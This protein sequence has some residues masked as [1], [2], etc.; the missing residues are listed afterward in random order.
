M[1]ILLYA[2]R[3]LHIPHL[4]PIRKWFSSNLPEID[5]R[6]SSPP[7]SQAVDGVTGVGL[8][9]W[10]ISSLQNSGGKWL[11]FTQIHQWK[12]DVTVMADADFGGID[13]GGRV[14]NVNHGLISKGTFYTKNPVVLRERGA[15]LICVPGPYHAEILRQSIQK[16]IVIT[17]VLKFDPIFQGVMT[18]EK[19]RQE[20]GIPE[21]ER[22]VLFAPTY[23]LELSAVPVVVDRIRD[24]VDEKTWL[25]VKLHGM[26]P[27][28]WIEMYRL[29]SKLEEKIIFIEDSD[30]APP[31]VA[32]DVVIS[33]VS[34]AFMEAVILDRPVILVNNPLQRSFAMYDPS[35]IEYSW[36]EV[37]VEVDSSQQMLLAVEHAL[38][39]PEYKRELRNFYGEKLA[40]SR[41]GNAAQRAC[42]AILQLVQFRSAVS[43]V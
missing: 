35:D 15:N 18:R 29:L 1:K 37:G 22:V 7:F 32:S 4:E 41:D 28:T 42:E 24:I 31:L 10:Q 27:A 20:Y 25:L 38:E 2:K 34:S 13:W 21:N 11:D 9:S 26:A 43:V 33:D 3:N 16:P 30:L 39:H 36:R 8:E 23:N 5:C 40:G 17:G 14:V 12:P 6:Y 19:L